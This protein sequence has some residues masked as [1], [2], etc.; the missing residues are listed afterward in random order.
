MRATLWGLTGL[1]LAVTITLRLRGGDRTVMLA[2]LWVVLTA[3]LLSLLMASTLTLLVGGSPLE[4]YRLLVAGT[5]G[6]TYAIGQVLFKATPL[7]LAGLSFTIASRAGL[8]NIG[9][10]GQLILGAFA[11]ALVGAHLPGAPWL[12]VPACLVAGAAAG[13]VPAALAG[14]FK[15]TRGANE[16]ITTMMLNFIIYAAMASVGPAYFMR[17]SVHTSPIRA[18]AQLARLEAFFP[19]LHGSAVSLAVVLPPLAALF[20]GWLLWRTPLGFSLRALGLGPDTAEASGVRTGRATILAMALSGAMAG[21]VGASFVLGY[22]RY[23]E[24]GF[25]GGIGFMGIAVGVLGG[26]RPLGV[27]AAALA[28]GTLSQGALAINA[29]VPKDLVDVLQATVIF[30]VV[31][32]SPAA[33]RLFR[34]TEVG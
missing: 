26:T 2:R 19:S 11:M 8:F 6:N 18:A 15:A 22:K 33:R 9:I 24:G 4:V 28:F 12:V 31:A 30:A 3:T 32:A 21:L 17:E 23:Y 34:T 29:V 10:E 5:W 7:A 13:A 25:S 14:V 27:L 1:S 20:V 16:V